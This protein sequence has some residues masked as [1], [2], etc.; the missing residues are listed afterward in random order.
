MSRSLALRALMPDEPHERGT[1]SRS[2]AC[3]VGQNGRHRQP[4]GGVASVRKCLF[5]N[6]LRYIQS[7]CRCGTDPA[8]LLTAEARASGDTS[9]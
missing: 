2:C 3:Q 5:D 7:G 1:T 9:F 8:L 4:G 6:M